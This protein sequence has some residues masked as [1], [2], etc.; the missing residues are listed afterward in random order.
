VVFHSTP[1]SMVV[2][3]V[4]ALVVEAAREVGAAALAEGQFEPTPVE[5]Q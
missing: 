5:T 2:G 4:Q 3:A 1:G